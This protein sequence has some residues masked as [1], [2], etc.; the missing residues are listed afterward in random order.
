[1]K[2]NIKSQAT[3][4]KK[5]KTGKPTLLEDTQHKIDLKETVKYPFSKKKKC[6][7][8]RMNSVQE[9]AMGQESHKKNV[10]K[11]ITQWIINHDH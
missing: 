11:S 2:E 3:F 9:A 10:G 5:S 7:L 8:C 6:G 4:K 1:M